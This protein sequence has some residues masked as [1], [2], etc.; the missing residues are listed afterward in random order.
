MKVQ[1]PSPFRTVE[2]MKKFIVFIVFVFLGCTTVSTIC[3]VAPAIV[4]P[5]PLGIG[6]SAALVANEFGWFPE[7]SNPMGNFL[8]DE[9]TGDIK[10]APAADPTG[11]A[12]LNCS[13]LGLTLGIK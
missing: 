11:G 9:D 5:T 6:V 4:Y 3:A 2:L 1:T 7:S 10:L 13:M 8:V 12:I